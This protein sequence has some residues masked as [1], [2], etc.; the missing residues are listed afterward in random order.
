MNWDVVQGVVAKVLLPV[1]AA[2][3]AWGI[4]GLVQSPEGARDFLWLLG[5]VALMLPVIKRAV[6]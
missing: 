6:E 4:V 3:C 1:G 2:C 5:G